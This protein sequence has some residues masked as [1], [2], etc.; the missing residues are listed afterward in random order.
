MNQMMNIFV[1]NICV[2]MLLIQGVNGTMFDFHKDLYKESQSH[3]MANHQIMIAIPHNN[4]D[5]LKE[6]LTER[7][8]PK[9]NLYQQWMTKDEIESLVS[10]EEA[11]VEI[12]KWLLGNKITILSKSSNY[13]R[14]VSSIQNLENLLQTKFH[15]ST[16]EISS[17]PATNLKA[18]IIVVLERYQRQRKR[19]SLLP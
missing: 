9:S 4:L 15:V 16:N 11:S 12:E 1:L 18:F 5:T 14:A 8:S 19:S 3:P 13:I 2:A 7:S 17:K 10:N 6:I